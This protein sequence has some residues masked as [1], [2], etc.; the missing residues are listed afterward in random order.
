MTSQSPRASRC[1]VRTTVSAVGMTQ[2]HTSSPA[3][4]RRGMP[5]L[6]RTGGVPRDVVAHRP[7][8][9]SLSRRGDTPGPI[10]F[11]R[12]F[13]SGVPSRCSSSCGN[14]AKAALVTQ[15]GVGYRDTTTGSG[16]RRIRDACSVSRRHGRRPGRRG[17]GPHRGRP[18]RPWTPP[19]TPDGKPDLQG[20]FTFATITPLQRPDGARGQGGPDARGGGRSS[21]RARTSA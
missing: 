15:A 12:N 1:A 19:R 17:C 13:Q 11:A 6:A 21:R 8:P 4:R 16:I 9:F 18:G 7:S 5:V 14:G 2:E 20:T 3:R 10:D